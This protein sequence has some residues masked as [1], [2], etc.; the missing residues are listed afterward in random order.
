MRGEKEQQCLDFI[1]QGLFT[2]D[3]K[4]ILHPFT[5]KTYEEVDDIEFAKEQMWFINNTAYKNYFGL[6]GKD[7]TEIE[8]IIRIA[9]PNDK[10]S[11]FPDFKFD[12][13]YIEHFQ[14]S[15]SKST[16]KGA[17]HLKEMSRFISKVNEEADSF[18]QECKNNFGE[19]RVKQWSI[20]NPDHNH[21]FLIKSFKNNWK[22]HLKS[23]NKYS[24]KKDVG[25]FMI[26]YSD[27]AL[28]M[29]ENIYEKWLNGMSQGDLRE[30][31]SL[32][33]YRL[34]RDRQLLDFIYSYE[35]TIKYV[36]FVYSQG[37][38]II[39]VKSIPYLLK[40]I[41]WDYKICQLTVK[42]VSTLYSISMTTD[43]QKK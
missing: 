16:K 41:P 27:S 23:L 30:Q 8:Q 39:K 26:E 14:I 18:K 13:G 36:I 35:E 32:N 11:E 9:K 3:G 42:N 20:D 22:N 24:G 10:A 21:S 12:Y 25:I 1:R 38:E 4:A 19:L 37:W 5:N 31:E 17:E 28:S 43:S 29:L 34:T 40:L 2:R 6:L 33:C 7:R 15:S